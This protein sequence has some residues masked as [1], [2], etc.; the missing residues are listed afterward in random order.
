MAIVAGDAQW[1]YT[2]GDGTTPVVDLL[3][4]RS[5][6]SKDIETLFRERG[7][8]YRL[9]QVEGIEEGRPTVFIPSEGPA[10]RYF[11]GSAEISFYFLSRFE[12]RCAAA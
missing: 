2:W 10:G 9:S 5:Q 3:L 4:D 11:Y 1:A 8:E 12:R 6:A 7:I